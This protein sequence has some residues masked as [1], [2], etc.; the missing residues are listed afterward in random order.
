MQQI[1][2]LTL[3]LLT[4]LI[5]LVFTPGTS[6]LFEFP[7]FLILISGTLIITTSWLYQIYQTRS[8]KIKINPIG[9]AILAV[10]LTQT[11]A[12]VFS[13]HPYTSFWGYYGR[14]HGGLLSTICYTIIYFAATNWLDKKN[15]RKLINI[16]MGTS[17]LVALLAILEHYNYSL[18]CIL[19]NYSTKLFSLSNGLTFDLPWHNWYTN[20][21]WSASTNPSNRSFS[22]LGQPNWLAAYL[23]PHFFL[24]LFQYKLNKNVQL[25]IPYYVLLI[26]FF[27]ALLFTRSRSG[28]VAFTISYVIYWILQIR[29]Y[30]TSKIKTP[31]LLVTSALIVISL[32]FGTPYSSSLK[33]ILT[34][35]PQIVTPTS[36]TVLENG[37]T[38]SGDIRKI[39]WSGAVK[40]IWQHPI[41]GS[42]PETFAYRY[43]AVRPVEHNLTS[44][45]D[46]LYNKAHNE[47]LNTAAGSGMLGLLAYL[48][49]HYVISRVSLTQIVKSKKINQDED[50]ELREFYPVLGATISAFTITSFFGFSVIPVYF[51]LL[52]FIIFSSTIRNNF[53]PSSFKFPPYLYLIFPLLLIYPV[54][55]LMADRAYTLG[56]QY[57]DAGKVDIAL[58]L[59]QKS[60]TYRSGLDLFHATLAEA[61]SLSNQKELALAEVE[62]NRNLNPVHLNFFRSRAKT[63]LTLAAKEPAYYSESSQEIE[64]ARVLA[65]TDPKLA[66][67]LGLIYT[68]TN[69]LSLA[70]KELKDAI[71]LKP[72][73]AEPYYALTLLYE[74]TK[75]TDLIPELLTHAKTNLATYSAQ[76]KEKID[77]YAT[78]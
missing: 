59:L 43:Y 6:E 11:V 5:P 69:Q 15:T 62:I 66:Y 35:V 49:F 60:L 30:K 44:E 2:A 78:N 67:N 14:F 54:R 18:S 63:Y 17:I 45:W 51:T 32:I 8:L 55:M 24:L 56:K 19:I 23:I 37:G 65:P 22:L 68:R 33:N 53:E 13:I 29:N 58:P 20:A 52:L 48:Y 77:K 26:I 27:I 25:R 39:V 7:K 3:Y 1:V 12:T 64:R 36:G 74:Q 61:Y 50:N 42:G 10:L 75:K 40:S 47:Y 16:S 28:F 70:E 9:Y 34:T 57:L 38:E 76:L 46:F 72:N 73:Y 71:I 31:I 41:I 21:C 4:I